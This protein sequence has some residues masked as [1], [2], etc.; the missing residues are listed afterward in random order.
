MTIA[1][2]VGALFTIASSSVFAGDPWLGERGANWEQNIVSTKTRAQVMNELAQAK[3]QGFV[4][5]GEEPNYPQTP[6]VKSRLTRDEVRA[7]AAQGKNNQQSRELYS[8][9][10]N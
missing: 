7:E 1:I 8:G 9:G 10:G 5:Y 3:A 6:V 2:A 4:F